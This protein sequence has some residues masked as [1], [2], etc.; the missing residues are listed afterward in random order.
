MGESTRMVDVEKLISYN[1]DLMEVLKDRRDI[2][3]V[4]Q[5]F[6]PF[7]DFRSHC[8]SDSKEI[9]RLLQ[10]L[11][12]RGFPHFSRVSLSSNSNAKEKDHK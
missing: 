5:C 11:F 4:T 10:G 2:A 1:D 3:N 12:S 9:Y 8:D 6:Q 7:N